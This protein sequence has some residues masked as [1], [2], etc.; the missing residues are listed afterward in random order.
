M[1]RQYRPPRVGD[2]RD[3]LAGLERASERLGY[4]PAVRLADG[5]RRTWE[6]FEARESAL[7]GGSG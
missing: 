4:R 7:T 2:V 3:S 6:W 1:A 5:L